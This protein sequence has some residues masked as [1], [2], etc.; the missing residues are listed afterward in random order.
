MKKS[1]PVRTQRLKKVAD[2]IGFQYVAEDDWGLESLLEDFY[3]FK[4]GRRR[5][6]RHLMQK[7]D[8]MMETN[9]YIFDYHFIKGYGK[10]RKRMAQTVFFI[11]SKHLGLPQFLMHPENF[12]NKAANWLG[13]QNDI[14]FVDYP[15]FSDQYRLD[16][17][18]EDFIRYSLNPHFL[19]F[20][21]IEQGWTLEGLNYFLIIYR[22]NR[23]IPAN[24][25][26]VLYKKGMH[27]L[28]MLKAEKL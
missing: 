17:D 14:D 20:F 4:K 21:S 16:G 15:K 26:E 9:M 19:Q 23:L 8:G 27:I 3:L 13:L 10:H 25:I 18:D 5:Q 12:F 22:K 6:I 28:E 11:D 2:K 7:K 24:S 1:T